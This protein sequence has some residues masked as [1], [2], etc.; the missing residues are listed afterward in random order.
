MDELREGQ[1]EIKVHGIELVNQ[2]EVSASVFA[3]KLSALVKALEAADALRHGRALHQ[4]TIAR[5]HTS[6]PTAILN[7]RP[8]QQN[9][10][11]HPSA[12]AVP[13][14][15]Q[16]I[17]AIKASAKPTPDLTRFATTIARL[18]RGAEKRFGFAEIRIADDR[19][20]R[21]DRFL[22]ERAKAMARIK[23]TDGVPEGGWYRG[24]V[25]GSFDGKLEFVDLRGALPQIKLT[26]S[27]GGKQIDCICRKEDIEAVRPALDRRVRVFGRAIY[28]GSTGLPRRVEVTD[29][30]V[31]PEPGDFTRWRGSFEPFAAPEWDGGDA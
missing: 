18:A 1:I 12:S 25:L 17:E 23:Q 8:L 31:L 9:V 20:L 4:Y 5:L 30:N 10:F 7:E 16:G 26:L 21:I 22:S 3:A 6:S 14:F 11:I 19:V 15:E 13:V 28:D 24:S 2:S 29:I 27:A